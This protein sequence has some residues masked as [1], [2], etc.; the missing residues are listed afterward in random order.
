MIEAEFW[1]LENQGSEHEAEDSHRLQTLGSFVEDLRSSSEPQHRQ[2]FSILSLVV[3][4]DTRHYL[5]T[6]TLVTS[7]SQGRR[8][9]S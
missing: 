5:I 3:E 2:F 6:Q 1:S 9:S 4:S 8:V 7:T